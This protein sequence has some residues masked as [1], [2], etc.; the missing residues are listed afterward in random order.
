MTE[1]SKAKPQVDGFALVFRIKLIFIY[2]KEY[3]HIHIASPVMLMR[4]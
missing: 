2:E 1:E 3:P 4:R